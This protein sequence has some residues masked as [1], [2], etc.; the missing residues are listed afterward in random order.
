M[1]NCFFQVKLSEGVA[2]ESFKVLDSYKES[3]AAG[4][5]EWRPAGF[6]RLPAGRGPSL[7]VGGR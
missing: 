2:K 1:E 3:L 5:I 7:E 4:L 6:S